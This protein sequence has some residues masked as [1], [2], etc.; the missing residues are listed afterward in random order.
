MCFLSGGRFIFELGALA[1]R[2][3]SPTPG[4][5]DTTRPS[6]RAERQLRFADVNKNDVHVYESQPPSPKRQ[7]LALMSP[8]TT[9]GPTISLGQFKGKMV[10]RREN[11][12]VDPSPSSASLSVNQ[13]S[14]N[15]DAAEGTPED[16]RRRFFPN[17]APH[18]PSLAWIEDSDTHVDPSS[19]SLRFDLSGKPIPPEDAEKLPT[20]LGLHHHAEGKHAGYTLDDIFLLSRSTV[21]AQRAS[22][23]DVLGKVARQLSNIARAQGTNIKE[24]EGRETDLRKRMLGAG[25]E[26]LPERGTVGIRGVELVWVCAVYWDKD[27]DDIEGIELKTPSDDVISPLP[28]EQYILPQIADAF[29]VASLP[30]ESLVQ[31]LD[32]VH[33]LARHSNDVA[34]LIVNTPHLLANLLQRL[35]LLAPSSSEAIS[36]QPEAIE[37]LTVL[38]ASS[39]ANATVVA[40]SADAL[41]RFVVTLPSASIYPESLATQLLISTLGLYRSLACYGLCAQLATTASEPLNSLAQYV[42]S[43]AS[44][45]EPLTEAWLLLLEA[46]MI[47][48]RDPHKTSPSHDILWSQV[49]GWGWGPDILK[50]LPSLSP[51]QTRLWKALWRAESAWLE[52]TS[53]NAPKGGEAE[54]TQAIAVLRTAFEGG[55]AQAVVENAVKELEAALASFSPAD[56]AQRSAWSTLSEP[57]EAIACA[58][59]LWLACLPAPNP[60][61]LDAPPFALPFSAIS[62]VCAHLTLHPLWTPVRNKTLP[63]VNLPLTRPLSLLLLVYLDFSRFLP[64]ASDDMWLAQ[65]F[66]IV[67]RLM[68]GDEERAAH[69]L[70]RALLCIT[71]AFMEARGLPAP[72]VIWERNG[73]ESIVPFIAFSVLQGTSRVAPLWPTSSSIASTTTL[74]LPAPAAEGASKVSA[75]LPVQRDWMFIA[76]DQLLR[77]GQSEVFK[78][79]PS[80]WD[81]SETEVVRASLLLTQVHREVLLHHGLAGFSLARDEVVFSCMKVFM[82]EHGQQQETSVDEVFRDAVV[83]QLMED[84]LAP[85]AFSA[86]SSS[87]APQALA[88]GPQLEEVAKAFLGSGTPFY[89]YYTDFVAL[90]DAISFSHPLF[91]RLLLPPLSMRYSSDYRKYLWADYAHVLRTVRTPID[92]VLSPDIREFLWPVEDNPEVLSAYLRALVKGHT[93]GFTHLVAVHHVACSIWPDLRNDDKDQKA[94]KL[95]QVVA[96]QAGPQALKDIVSYRQRPDALVLPPVCFVG[97]EEVKEARKAFAQRAG[98][99]V[100]DRLSLLLE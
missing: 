12:Q 99:A 90:Y 64:G 73:M 77:S 11:G 32:V 41:L 37:T 47:C 54:K 94:V 49:A 88:S 44:R 63:H 50:L 31:L 13:P 89:Q 86:A 71:P 72:P 81:F 53:I 69:L 75:P 35:V 46:W 25:L 45:S 56:I 59:R 28:L 2:A 6:S 61:V 21:P 15:G 22:M 87:P 57:A 93:D 80:S 92:A 79:L 5:T 43:G 17:A 84:L 9:D 26:A 67:L 83:G 60:V 51:G 98:T 14:S 29:K 18:D 36:P 76:L 16:I 95:L 3:T 62:A 10:D 40:E 97:L 74:R 38:A 19:S 91:A 100:M 20:H 78:S 1:S 30:H 33:R 48:A 68:P 24:L 85:F 7:P 55:T 34:S 58:V 96:S 65:A 8:T 23:L 42:F 39:R 27:L 70:E 66:S 52:G 4:S 82:L